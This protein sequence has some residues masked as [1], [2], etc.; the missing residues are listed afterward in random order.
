MH[1]ILCASDSHSRGTFADVER[2]AD[3]AKILLFEKIA[4][5]RL[6]DRRRQG[7]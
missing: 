5:E 3:F 2:R 6:C 7:A 4:A 1:F